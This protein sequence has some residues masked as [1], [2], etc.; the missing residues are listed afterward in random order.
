M[1]GAAFLLLVMTVFG[2]HGVFR[3]RQM[4]RDREGLRERVADLEADTARL[5]RRLD[6]HR[7]GRISSELVA[8]ERL[9]LLKPGE[10]VYDFRPD[11]LR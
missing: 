11:A 5:R 7:A 4:N 2:D 9:G 1:G 8:R 6:D 3:I 10:V